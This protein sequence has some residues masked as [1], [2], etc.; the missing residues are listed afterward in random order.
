MHHLRWIAALLVGYSHIRQNLLVDYSGLRHPG[1]VDKAIFAL[2]NY[3]HAGVVIFFVLSGYLVGGKAISLFQSDSVATEWQHFFADRF[4]R[5]FVVLL[6]ALI[7]SF[8]VLLY[9]RTEAANAPFMTSAH[10]GWAMSAPID[11]D[12]SLRRWVS[13][14]ILLNEFISKSLAVD[15]PLWSLAYEWFYYMAALGLVL[16]ARKVFSLAALVAITYAA[17]LF[18]LAL[19]F[20][21]HILFLGLLWLFGVI[22]KVVFDRHFLKRSFAQWLGI[23]LFL[24]LMVV[25]RVVS[26]NDM[27]LGFAVAFMIAHSKWADWRAGERWGMRLAAFSYSFYVVHFPITLFVLGLLYQFDHIQR[28]LPLDGKG[29][30]IAGGTLV[31]TI[32]SSRIFAFFTEDRT[33]FIRRKIW[34]PATKEPVT[35]PQDSSVG[36]LPRV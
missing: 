30:A 27:L 34:L 9:L 13:A 7:L 20:N 31:A 3:G 8:A 14:S 36:G 6:P 1:I 4:S 17:V 25:D 2:A 29:L 10:W 19:I 32:I 23:T 12:F 18:A 33:G 26:V 24:G 5:I 28:R 11:S 16:A 35:L 15:S 22:A 21:S